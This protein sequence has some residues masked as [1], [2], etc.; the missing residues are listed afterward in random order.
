MTATIGVIYLLHFEVP[1]HHARHYLGWTANLPAR[2]DDHA[3]GNG[4]RL[5]AAVHSAGIGWHLARIWG[6]TR[7]RER[8]I[9][10]QGGLSRSCPLCGVIPATVAARLLLKGLPAQYPAYTRQPDKSMR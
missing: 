9:K 8:Q 4:A 5:L 3:A 7:A 2:L 10:R 1:F 6:G